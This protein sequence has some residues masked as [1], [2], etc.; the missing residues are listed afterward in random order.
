MLLPDAKKMVIDWLLA[1]SSLRSYVSTRVYSRIPA[2]KKGAAENRFPL[3][4]VVRIPSPP[5]FSRPLYVDRPHLQVDVFGGSEA[6]TWDIAAEVAERL[7][8]MP[9]NHH[10]VEGVVTDV[11]FLN[12]GDQPDEEF[13][14]AKPRVRMDVRLT[15]HPPQLLPT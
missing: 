7:E 3:V 4:R 12:I 2:L 15:T 8:A 14:P 1:D 6:T 10:S 11:K 13:N 5:A 9:G